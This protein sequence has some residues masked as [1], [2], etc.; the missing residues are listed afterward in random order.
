[1]FV[2]EGFS[3]A[4]IQQHQRFNSQRRYLPELGW[5]G[6]VVKSGV[7]G[8]E[9]ELLQVFEAKAKFTAKGIITRCLSMSFAAAATPYR[10]ASEY[11]P[12][13]AEPYEY[14]IFRASEVKDLAVEEVAPQPPVRN[15]HDDPAVIGASAPPQAAY[16]PYAGTQAANPAAAAAFVQQQQQVQQ[17]RAAQQAQVPPRQQ[18][19]TAAQIVAGGAG[20]AARAQPPRRNTNNVQTAAASLETVERA[21]G[22]LRVSNANAARGGR[23]GNQGGP[24]PI[25]VPNTDF[26]FESSNAR[27]D[28]RSLT[29]NAKDSDVETNPSDSEGKD[30]KGK[31]RESSAY[32]PTKSFFDELT[33]APLEPRGGRGRR[34][35]GP[36]GRNRREEERERNVAT[37][38]EPGGVGLLG[39]GA[40]VGGWGGYGRRGGRGGMRGGPRRGRGGNPPVGV[41]A[42]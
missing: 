6:W 40:Y 3:L 7:G 10:P 34:G 5:H 2:T 36:G 18:Q 27:F 35:G 41:G 37:F 39:P 28:K 22:D 14:I 16:S 12:P 38:G 11:I 9:K 8:D 19:Q 24:K 23:R 31:A 42:G 26:D 33:P 15:V 13:V 17:Q 29:A 25:S 1:M 4:L 30:E 21:L 20:N 32:H